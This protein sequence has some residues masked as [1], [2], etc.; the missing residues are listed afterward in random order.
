MR[1]KQGV[2]AALLA[3]AVFLPSTV[4]A[5]KSVCNCDP[6]ECNKTL[7]QVAEEWENRCRCTTPNLESM[8]TAASDS[9]SSGS[10]EE[11]ESTPEESAS[12]F[13]EILRDE[14]FVYL[15]DRKTAR[16]LPIPHMAK[17]KM[18]DVWIKLE[19]L[20]YLEGDYTYPAKYY[21]EHYLIR[22]KKQQIQ[23]LAEMEVAGRPSSDAENKRYDGRRWE[24]LIPGTIEDAIYHAVL[25]HKGDIYDESSANGTAIRDFIENTI[26][27]SL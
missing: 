10:D 15:M 17:E 4:M 18:I 11:N 12:R 27:V 26:N 3:A 7:E 8:E 23:F 19:P 14:S 25:R 13:I 6:C 9:M 16:F 24:D 2:A 1:G 21:L 5:E 22:P 20:E